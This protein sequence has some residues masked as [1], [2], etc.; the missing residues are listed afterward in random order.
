MAKARRILSV[1]ACLCLFATPLL[2]QNWKP[3]DPAELAG[4]PSPKVDKDAPAEAIFWEIS[5][6]DEITE[7]ITSIWTNYIRIK[8][9]STLGVEQQSKV[10]IR[11]ATGTDVKDIAGRTIKPNGSIV[12]LLP[13]AINDRTLVSAN[14]VKVKAKS[15]VLPAVEPGSIIE[16]RWTERRHTLSTEIHMNVQRDIPIQT[17]R[18]RVKP[19]SFG[20]ANINMKWFAFNMAV[21][22]TGTDKEKFWNMTAS[23]VPAFKEESYMPPDAQVRQW[24]MLYYDIDRKG[25]ANDVW[26]EIGKELFNDGKAALKFNDDV[27]RAATAAVAG[28]TTQEEKL[29][30]LYDFCHTTIKRSTDDASGLTTDQKKKLKE[31]HSAADVLKRKIG[32]SGD[33]LQLFGAMA[34]SQGMDARYAFVADRSEMFFRRDF[35][36]RTIV[37]GVL[38]AVKV[39]AGWRLFHPSSSYLPADMLPWE[40][41]GVAA[42]IADQQKPILM[43]TP[44]SEPAK[45]AIHRKGTFTLTADGTLEGDIRS[46][47]VGHSAA[48][49]KED[50]DDLE[51]SERETRLKEGLESRLGQGVDVSNMKFEN[52]T[53]P[54]APAVFTYHIKV[55]GYAQRTGRRLFFQPGFFRKGIKPMLSGDTRVHPV[56]I[57]YPWVEDDDIAITLPDGFELEDAENLALF[58]AK[59]IATHDVEIS[60]SRDGRAIRYVRKMGFTIPALLFQPANYTPLKNLFQLFH[61]RDNHSLTLRQS[62]AVKR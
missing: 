32:D 17:V 24:V 16:Y 25:T 28:A 14:Q 19:A 30:K 53:D 40:Y 39:D 7:E 6:H 57:D 59:T 27:K 41:E 37:P 23:N 47:F 26:D 38:V 34:A 1:A 18:Y 42:L 9:F 48:T 50:Y 10:D 21:P 55:P 46:E 15:F 44:I 29:R 12:E 45:S 61:E 20:I 51:P 33:I 35:P 36:H 5:I 43:T 22:V 58:D 3:V 2:A 11:Y 31:N 8:V 4:M 52:I 62:E 49:Q 60:R 54:I 56:Y 13:N